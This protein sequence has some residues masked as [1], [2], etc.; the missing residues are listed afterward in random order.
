MQIS[1]NTPI[2][3]PMNG[4]AMAPALDVSSLITCVRTPKDARSLPRGA[5]V[6]DVHGGLTFNDAVAAVLESRS[7]HGWHDLDL[8]G[9]RWT[10][11]Y[12][13]R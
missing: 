11:I 6:G 5:M 13:N 7:L 4:A 12:L 2:M 8:A 9:Q 10:I 3:K 1:A